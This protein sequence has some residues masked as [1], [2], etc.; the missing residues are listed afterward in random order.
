MKGM[1]DLPN[2]QPCFGPEHRRMNPLLN[3]SNYLSIYLSP[4]CCHI[5]LGYIKRVN[6]LSLG[7][8]WDVNFQ[9]CIVWKTAT[10]NQKGDKEDSHRDD[11]TSNKCLISYPI[12]LGGCEKNQFIYL[13]P[14][15]QEKVKMN[16]SL[17]F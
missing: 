2:L 13:T 3:Y 7:L 1:L 9:F 14:R 8:M 11:Q 15:K 17:F 10:K 12:E 5:C 4:L 6:L 16:I